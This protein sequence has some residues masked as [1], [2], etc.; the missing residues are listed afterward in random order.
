MIWIKLHCFIENACSV[1]Y[2]ERRRKTVCVVCC[3]RLCLWKVGYKNAT[4]QP[5]CDV[6]FWVTLCCVWHNCM[7]GWLTS[8]SLTCTALSNSDKTLWGG[9]DHYRSIAGEELI[10]DPAW[11]TNLP[12]DTQLLHATWAYLLPEAKQNKKGWGE[13]EIGIGSYKIWILLP[14]LSL[15][16]CM[17][18]K[19]LQFCFIFQKLKDHTQLLLFFL[20]GFVF[21]M[22][23]VSCVNTRNWN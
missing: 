21:D 5:G 16:T 19:S 13:E 22:N 7:C 4:R 10:R 12:Q 15:T 18:D 1:L 14:I 23:S 2:R 9:Y 3:I 6:L 8:L 17:K 20:P 11:C